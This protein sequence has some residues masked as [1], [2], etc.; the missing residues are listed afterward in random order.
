MRMRRA[1]GM[2]CCVGC[3]PQIAMRR[4][5]DPLLCI[6]RAL[7]LA[8]ALASAGA[9][10]STDTITSRA[11]DRSI[12]VRI[13]RQGDTLVIAASA[14]LVADPATAWAVL[15]DYADYRAFIP[16]IRA[17]RV[18]E[19]HGSVVVVEQSDELA[20]WFLHMPVRVVYE[21]DEFPRVRLQSR[22]S[23][24]ALPPLSSTFVL[25]RTDTGVRLGYVGHVGPGLPLLG[26]IEQRALQDVAIR[27]LEA[28][29]QEIE[30]R[31]R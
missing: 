12:D 15:T 24:P 22:A 13:E 4:L 19:R 18:V 16:G 23:A 25:E 5:S 9:H 27:D 1:R 30:R 21:I 11:R 17:S 3:L 6:V 28:L 14:R 20:V 7:A 2:L 10:A 31:A 29:V 26:R 8:S